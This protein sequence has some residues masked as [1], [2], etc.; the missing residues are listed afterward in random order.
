MISRFYLDYL[1][2]YFDFEKYFIRADPTRSISEKVKFVEEGKHKD[3][4]YCAK[5]F[6]YKSLLGMKHLNAG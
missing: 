1:K 6:I 2:N 5:L 3:F 4:S